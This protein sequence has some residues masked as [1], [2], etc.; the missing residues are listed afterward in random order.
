MPTT[1]YPVNLPANAKAINTIY[2][3]SLNPNF[4]ITWS[5]EFNLSGSNV[6]SEGGFT[7][8]LLNSD[9]N[10]IL[11]GGNVGIDLGYSG[12]SGGSTFSTN[13]SAGLINAIL[14]IGFDSTGLFALSTSTDGNLARNGYGIGNSNILPN[15]IVIRSGYPSF[16]LISSVSCPFNIISYDESYTTIRCRLGNIGRTL[17]VDYRLSSEDFYTNIASIPVSLNIDS[18]T[19]YNVGISFASPISSSQEAN[20]CVL[21]VKNY[22]LEGRE[23]KPQTTDTFD[24]LIERDLFTLLT[25]VSTNCISGMVSNFDFSGVS[26]NSLRDSSLA[27]QDL[28][29]SKIIIYQWPYNGVSSEVT[30]FISNVTSIA[31][32]YVNFPEDILP[33]TPSIEIVSLSSNDMI[34]GSIEQAIISLRASLSTISKLDTLSSMQGLT[35]IQASFPDVTDLDSV[36]PFVSAVGLISYNLNVNNFGITPVLF[37]ESENVD[38]FFLNL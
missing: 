27:I 6:N 28:W 4:D 5:F 3:V 19:V 26:V 21:R 9:Y 15:S 20:T 32:N 1:G 24:E 12:L 31:P 11:S 29:S 23:D 10:Y 2:P 18:N 34:I 14:G 30:N 25:E 7:T 13:A 33:Q 17:F 35:A 16:S 38:Y 36:Y 22:H 37:E 8:F